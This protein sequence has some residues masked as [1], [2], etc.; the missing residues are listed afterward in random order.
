MPFKER[1]IGIL[2]VCLFQITI[3]YSLV[4]FI[5]SCVVLTDSHGLYLICLYYRRHLLD[6]FI[7]LLLLC[8]Q[9][10]ASYTE[11]CVLRYLPLVLK[12][13]CKCCIFKVRHSD[14]IPIGVG[15]PLT[16]YHHNREAKD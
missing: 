15:S 3:L 6:I 9:Y 1:E 16:N 11:L 4:T 7:T 2:V 5:T 10:P 14:S 12:N 8:A 13:L